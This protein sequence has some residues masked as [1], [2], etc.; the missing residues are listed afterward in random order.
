MAFIAQLFKGSSSGGRSP[1][2]PVEGEYPQD[3][4]AH[5]QA[6]PGTAQERSQQGA[7]AHLHAVGRHGQAHII[8]IGMEHLP[9]EADPEDQGN[10]DDI[11]QNAGDAAQDFRD[12][13]QACSLRSQGQ[14][15]Q[16]THQGSRQEQ[17]LQGFH[18]FSDEEA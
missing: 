7:H 6:R 12:G 14:H 10:H 2:A 15:H 5:G 18:E 9:V 8:Q 1:V 11:D 13:D 17:F 16:A 4:P 3:A